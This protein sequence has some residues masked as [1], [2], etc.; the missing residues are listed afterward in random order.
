MHS[1]PQIAA[2]ARQMG[3]GLARE[4]VCRKRER[5]RADAQRRPSCQQLI[6]R[7]GGPGVGCHRDGGGG[8]H[9]CCGRDSSGM[10]GSSR[11]TWLHGLPDGKATMLS[12]SSVSCREGRNDGQQLSERKQQERVRGQRLWPARGYRPASQTPRRWAIVIWAREGAL[13]EEH[14]QGRTHRS[15]QSK[16]PTPPDGESRTESSGH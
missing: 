10:L 15:R 16:L 8:Q 6:P 7:P 1:S 4:C 12:V 3:G 9:T 2:M 13:A 5:S 14:D 11:W